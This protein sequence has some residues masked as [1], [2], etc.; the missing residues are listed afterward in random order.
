M[1]KFLTIF[2][3]IF[4]SSI[5]AAHAAPLKVIATQTLFADLVRQI[6]KEKVEVKSVAPPKFNVHFIQPKPSDVR[7]V[8]AADLYVN[9]GLD[10]EAWSDPLVEAAGKPEFFRGG[11]RSLDLSQ[12]L[13]L[14]NP[15]MGVL[16]RALGDL[17]IFGNPHYHMNPENAKIMAGTIVK[18]LQ[19]IDS[20]NAAFYDENGKA[21]IAKL[22]QKITEWK[23]SCA[24]CAGKEIISYHADIAYVTD[25]LGLK[26]EQFLEPKPGIPPTPRHLEFLQSYAKSHNVIAI[27][28]P[29]YYPQDAADALSKKVGVKVATICQNVGEV[30][31]TDD[32]FS[33]FDY[34]FRQIQRLLE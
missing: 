2:L 25:F 4:L 7:N 1:K 17:H 20:Q 9:A 26:A 13:R 11:D 34:N 23:A 3:F 10:L 6:G 5:S 24:G 14:L 21:L 19:D 29:T 27:V 32:V 15:P 8:A 12:G 22:D 18:K 28:M 16:S 31:G 30:P 33:F